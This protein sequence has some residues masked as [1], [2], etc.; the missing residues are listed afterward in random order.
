VVASPIHYGESIR[1]Q[2]SLGSFHKHPCPFWVLLFVDLNV[3]IGYSVPMT[4]LFVK[5]ITKD[6]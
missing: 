4:L 5:Y 6:F 3:S 2:V 1:Q